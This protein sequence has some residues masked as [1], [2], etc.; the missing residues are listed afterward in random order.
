MN[1]NNMIRLVLMAV[2]IFVLSV[3]LGAGPAFAGGHHSLVKSSSG[4]TT[5]G[6]ITNPGSGPGREPGQGIQPQM[7][8][9][10]FSRVYHSARARGH[11]EFLAS[12]EASLVCGSN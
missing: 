10:C 5:G 2:V 3:P 4:P 6:G 12:S 1:M 7:K 11:D 8:N 9:N